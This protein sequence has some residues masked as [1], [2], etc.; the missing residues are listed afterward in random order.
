MFCEVVCVVCMR[1]VF[2]VVVVLIV[3]VF[4]CGLRT[5]R[6]ILQRTKSLLRF[7]GL[8]HMRNMGAELSY[9]T[10]VEYMLK[11]IFGDTFAKDGYWYMHPNP[12]AFFAMIMNLAGASDAK[13]IDG[14][15]L[16][17]LKNGTAY[18]VN[19]GKLKALGVTESNLKELFAATPAADAKLQI[20]PTKP[21][22]V[23]RPGFEVDDRSYDETEALVAIMDI[24]KGNTNERRASA[25]R[26]APS[27]SNKKSAAKRTKKP[28][29]MGAAAMKKSTQLDRLAEISKEV[30]SRQSRGA[31][32]MKDVDDAV[33][34]KAC[35]DYYDDEVD[36]AVPVK[37]L[38]DCEDHDMWFVM[39]DESEEVKLLDEALR[40][41]LPLSE[42][43]SDYYMVP[44]PGFAD[45]SQ[46]IKIRT[47]EDENA[48]DLFEAKNDL[49]QVEKSLEDALTHH[50][51]QVAKKHLQAIKDIV[52]DALSRYEIEEGK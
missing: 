29:T 37:A 15:E 27:T 14:A 49:L 32:S 17:K 8:G 30:V 13:T 1:C 52:A 12:D 42:L 18:E 11:Q 40:L 38:P 39:P 5:R 25:K 20:R 34:Y 28:T 36:D 50:Q 35:G 10:R 51:Y 21:I 3:G 9:R 2:H 19:K 46:C 22:W 43:H 26:D 31:S 47:P 48:D 45:P 7:L 41:G 6:M 16:F 23:P 4:F 24:G 33:Q 44:V